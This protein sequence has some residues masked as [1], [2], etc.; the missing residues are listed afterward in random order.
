MLGDPTGACTNGQKLTHRGRTDSTFRGRGHRI[1]QGD[2]MREPKKIRKELRGGPSTRRPRVN[3][4]RLEGL[5][6]QA[7]PLERP[8]TSALTMNV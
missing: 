3:H 5:Q 8:W 1:A 2:Q 4:N 6:D 7:P